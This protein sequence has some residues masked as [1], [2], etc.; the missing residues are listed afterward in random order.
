MT[1]SMKIEDSPPVFTLEQAR[2]RVYDLIGHAIQPQIWLMVL[3]VH[4]QQLSLL[5][6]IDGIP[7]RP[8]PGSVRPFAVRINEIVARDAPGGSLIVTLERPGSAALT[9]PDQAWAIELTESFGKL[10]RISGLFVA[11]D[12]GIAVLAP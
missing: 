10:M 2:N 3:D 5:I 4:G 6:P 9:A 7:V 1:L 11:H 12:D 8:E